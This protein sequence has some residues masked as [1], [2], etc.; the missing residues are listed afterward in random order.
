LIFHLDI[1]YQTRQD[2][3]REER[4]KCE[5][6]KEKNSGWLERQKLLLNQLMPLENEGLVVA[7]STPS[8]KAAFGDRWAWVWATCVF[9]N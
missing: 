3:S 7:I 9:K 1:L 6:N 8:G 2:N 4:E 5:E